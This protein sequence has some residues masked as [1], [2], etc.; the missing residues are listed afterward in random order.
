MYPGEGGGRGELAAERTAGVG[1]F[2]TT[3]SSSMV[4][5]SAVLLVGRETTAHWRAL[6]VVGVGVLSSSCLGCVLAWPSR[7]WQASPR[8]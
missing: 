2:A 6:H 3:I 7:F 8:C 5:A 1:S 4:H